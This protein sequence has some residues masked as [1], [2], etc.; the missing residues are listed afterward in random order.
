MSI[1]TSGDRGM[2]LDRQWYKGSGQQDDNDGNKKDTDKDS[3]AS[4]SSS[5]SIFQPTT[6]NPL[7]DPSRNY[8]ILLKE[9]PAVTTRSAPSFL[10][11]GQVEMHGR[12]RS[13]EDF[14]R[15]VAFVMWREFG[16]WIAAPLQDEKEEKR[17]NKKKVI[18]IESESSTETKIIEDGTTLADSNTDKTTTVSTSTPSPPDFSNPRTLS[19]Y[20]TLKNVKKLLLIFAFRQARMHAEWL[21]IGHIHGNMNNDNALFS[22]YS[23]DFGPFGNLEGEYKV[24]K[25]G[26]AGGASVWVGDGEGRYIFGFLGF[27]IGALDRMHI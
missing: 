10:R 4:S 25:L 19:H 21:R 20:L 16:E 11:I 24:G 18:F 5:T 9:Q 22:G 3:T 26:G 14:K 8:E 15:L 2:R 17:N 7:S 1:I 27:R 13:L 12:I 6:K 23:I